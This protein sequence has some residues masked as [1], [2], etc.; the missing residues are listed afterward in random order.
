MKGEIVIFSIIWDGRLRKYKVKRT[1]ILSLEEVM[2]VYG[3]YKTE[4]EAY[5]VIN[6]LKKRQGKTRN[7]IKTVPKPQ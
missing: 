6:G 7:D 2:T 1:A 5:I 4:R 3:H